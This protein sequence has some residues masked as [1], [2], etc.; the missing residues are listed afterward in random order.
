MIRILK[1]CF[2]ENFLNVETPLL[3]RLKIS[4]ERK[5]SFWAKDLVNG[6]TNGFVSRKLRDFNKVS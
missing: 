6:R 4:V 5:S 3:F 1:K 2:W